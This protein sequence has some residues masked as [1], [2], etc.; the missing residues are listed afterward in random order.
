MEFAATF[1]LRELPPNFYANPYPV[2]DVLLE[3]SLVH[4]MPDGSYFSTRHADL[5][6]VYWDAP[7]FSSDKRVENEPK[8]GAT[9]LLFEHHT[10]SL[11]FNDPLLHTRVCSSIIAALTR[12]AIAGIDSSLI[13]LV[14]SLLDNLQAL[15]V[16]AI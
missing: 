1:D 14:D 8:Y 16:V 4:P 10:T 9:S 5:I 6:A 13:T 7:N 2:Y 3:T 11:V 12:R 15:K